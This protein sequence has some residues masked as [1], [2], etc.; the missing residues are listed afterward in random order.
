MKT[1][2]FNNVP[3]CKR[4]INLVKNYSSK[5]AQPFTE[6]KKFFSCKGLLL[7]FLGMCYAFGL[8]AEV[9]KNLNITAGTLSS[10]LTQAELE[11]VTSLTLT[12]T[13]DARDFKTMRDNM[14]LLAEVDLSGTAIVSYFGDGGTY[15]F[16]NRYDANVIPVCW[17]YNPYTKKTNPTISK[18]I[19]PSTISLIEPFAFYGCTALSYVNIPSSVIKI[20][21]WSFQYCSSLPAINIPSSVTSIE[22]SAFNGCTS[23]SSI[24]IP[25]SVTYLGKS[26]LSNINALISV[27]TNNPEYSSK[28]GILYNKDLTTIIQSP[29]SISGDLIIPEG[30]IT[31]GESAFKDCSR[32]TSISIPASVKSIGASA[33]ENCSSVNSITAHA[34]TPINLS[35]SNN[36]FFNIKPT[37]KLYVPFGAKTLYASADKWY[38]FINIVESP[39]IFLSAKSVTMGSKETTTTLNIKAS[40]SIKI[41]S[42]QP[43]LKFSSTTGDSGNT[44]LTL[45][46]DENTTGEIL[47]ATITVSAK[48]LNDQLISVSKLGKVSVTA[49]GLSNVLSELLGSVSNLALTGT[50]DARDFKTMRDQMPL[51]AVLDLSEVRIASYTGTEGSKAGNTY[52]SADEIPEQ[53]FYKA[54]KY[55]GKTSL[56]SIIFPSKVKILGTASFIGCTGLT[57][58]TLP[59]GVT[60]IKSSV[61]SKCSNLSSVILPSSITYIASGAFEMCTGLTSLNLPESVTSID[62]YTFQGCEGFSLINIPSSV[63]TIGMYAFMNCLNATSITIPS[64]VTSIHRNAFDNCSYVNAITVLSGVPVDLSSSLEVF[65]K[66]NTQT[67]ILNVPYGSKALYAS[68]SQWKDFINIAESPDVAPVAKAG[69]NQTINEGKPV[70]LNG[71]GSMDADGNAFTYQ[72][73]APKGI[74]LSSTTA[75][76]PTFTAPEVQNDTILWFTLVVNDGL[77]ASITDSVFI[78]VKQ[79]HKAP[80]AHAGT[81]Q[82]INENELVT[83]DGL[84]SYKLENGNLTYVWKAPDG[85]VLSSATAANPTF[86]APEVKTDTD[87]ILSLTVNDGSMNSTADNVTITVKQ[88]NKAPAAHAG[89]DQAMSEATLVTLNGMGSADA[90]GNALTYLWT[91]PKGIVLSSATSAKPTFTAP[92]VNQDTTYT[93]SLVVNDGLLNSTADTIAVLVKNIDKAPYVKAPIKNIAVDKGSAEKTID[94]KE[95]FADNDRY[96]VLSYSVASNSNDKV[97]QASI[98]GTVLTLKFSSNSIGTSDMVITASANGKQADTKFKVDLLSPLGL[99]PVAH[100]DQCSIY[101]NPTTGR[102]NFRMNQTAPKGTFLTVYDMSGKLILCQP[103]SGK[104]Q[105]IDLGGN[106]AGVYIIQTNLKDNKAQ[107]VVLK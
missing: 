74:V 70:T 5:F 17:F 60:S 85:I 64:S 93:F 49:G 105:W 24:K 72:W 51:L 46:A 66:I 102:I 14:P 38:D 82:Q 9:S 58:V 41:S 23:L 20:R 61:F 27:D 95:V 83:L 68:A 34:L 76:N 6:R 92:E 45:T 43:W 90:D 84:Q 80:V 57:S 16:S 87:Y 69:T 48:G 56:T 31:I 15:N 2:P 71:S 33:F 25:A 39:G 37:I 63:K 79:V 7:L 42:D 47:K 73:T 65:N 8:H 78:T 10:S 36:V 35:A 18:V 21:A 54:D 62:A 59:S 40:D 67:T 29:L 94:L 11:T 55:T 99:D 89:L 81:D 52:Y 44:M 96:D 13:V 106:P 30:V 100:N 91:A 28:D 26:A 88:V 107:K 97:V 103:I 22:E 53:A 104:E 50:I 3:L 4:P 77:L 101:P 86:T 1:D 75:A 12:G 32:L 98:T 19:L